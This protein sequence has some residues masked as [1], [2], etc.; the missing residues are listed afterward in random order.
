VPDLSALPAQR[1][2]TTGGVTL[3]IYYKVAAHQSTALSAALQD[4]ADGL[5]AGHALRVMRRAEAVQNGL[6]TWMEIHGPFERSTVPA[7]L[8]LI[9]RFARQIGL[10]A[11]AVNGRVVEQ[12]EGME[13]LSRCA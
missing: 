5:P 3:F 7:R 11:L 6:E 10:E 12:F 8:E 4:L 1:S 13:G 2:G 9:S